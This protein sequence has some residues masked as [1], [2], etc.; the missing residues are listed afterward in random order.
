MLRHSLRSIHDCESSQSLLINNQQH[1]KKGLRVYSR[2]NHCCF[3]WFA[4]SKITTTNHG[5]WKDQ[6][7]RPCCKQGHFQNWYSTNYAQSD[8]CIQGVSYPRL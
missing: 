1:K 5:S 4:N 7:N 8:S 6:A 2:Q 3:L